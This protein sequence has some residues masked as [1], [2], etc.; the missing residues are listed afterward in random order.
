MK[1]FDTHCHIH[2]ANYGL[3]AEQVYQAARDES[4]P[5]MLAVGCTIEDSR[6]G[7]EFAAEHEGVWA[8]VGLHPHEAKHYHG[9]TDVLAELADLAQRDEVVAIGECGLDYYYEHSPREQQITVFEQQLQIAHDASLPLSFHVRDAFDDFLPIIANFPDVRGVVHSFTAGVKVMERLLD[10]G[11]YLGLN[12]I[13]T[14]TK[15]EAQRA[16]ARAVP[17][18]RMLLETDAPFLTP[19]RFRG[20]I[21][22]PKHVAETGRFLAELRGESVEVIASVTT[23]N[24]SRLFAVSKN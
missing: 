21:C 17:L 2:F 8:A 23:T 10:K 1:F 6:R 16:M 12:G 13:M 24:A 3:P 11:F 20:S 5:Y 7:V 18:E 4:V 9:A 15:D 14:F 22:E 19:K